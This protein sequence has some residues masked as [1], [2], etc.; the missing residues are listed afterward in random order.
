MEAQS[1]KLLTE[2]YTKL[3]F[4]FSITLIEIYEILKVG[5]KSNEIEV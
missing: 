4:Q 5:E 2:A 1:I 3:M